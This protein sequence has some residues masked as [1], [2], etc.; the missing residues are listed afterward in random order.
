MTDD[1]ALLKLKEKVNN[2]EF[3]LLSGDVELLKKQEKLANISIFG[4]SSKLFTYVNHFD[5]NTL[6][7]YPVGLTRSGKIK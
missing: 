5:E 1:Y 2:K 3:I 4:Y 7:A 6:Q